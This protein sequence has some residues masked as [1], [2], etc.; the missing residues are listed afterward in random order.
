MLHYC[1]ISVHKK[2]SLKLSLIGTGE[3]NLREGPYNKGWLQPGGRSLCNGYVIL[4]LVKAL[5]T[6]VVREV[7]CFTWTLQNSTKRVFYKHW[8]F[9]S[10]RLNFWV[11]D[12]ECIRASKYKWDDCLFGVIWKVL[13]VP[14]VTED[15]DYDLVADHPHGN[16]ETSRVIRSKNQRQTK[17]SYE[18]IK[19]C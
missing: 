14:L 16:E 15:R 18:G 1:G 4:S 12:S 7:S 19:N 10:T 3:A 8:S 6:F 17:N 13:F 11:C 2:C 9:S 5:E